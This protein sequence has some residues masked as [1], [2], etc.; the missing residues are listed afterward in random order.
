MYTRLPCITTFEHIANLPCRMTKHKDIPEEVN[1]TNCSICAATLFY[2]YTRSFQSEVEEDPALKSIFWKQSALSAFAY[3]GSC[4]RAYSWHTEVSK[5]WS[6]RSNSIGLQK[7][8]VIRFYFKTI[9][10][11]HAFCNPPLS[12]LADMAVKGI[13]FSRYVSFQI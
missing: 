4:H 13:E 9:S 7:Y 3:A 10:A 1:L 8:L 6:M 11:R 12:L 2:S 5:S